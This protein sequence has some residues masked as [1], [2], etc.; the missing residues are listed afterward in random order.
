M[1]KDTQADLF[2]TQQQTTENTKIKQQ[3]FKDS[4]ILGPIDKY[5]KYGIFPWKFLIHIMLMIMT[6][7]II[8]LEIVPQTGFQAQMQSTVNGLF[9]DNDPTSNVDPVEIHGLVNIY[10]IPDLRQFV[11]NTVV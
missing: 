8:L 6:A 1:T 2:L 9:L 4:L 10:T 5:V 7:W 3:K 11:N